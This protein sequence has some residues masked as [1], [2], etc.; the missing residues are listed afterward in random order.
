LDVANI[1][2]GQNN[3]KVDMICMVDMHMDIGFW[4]RT[5]FAY[6]MPSFYA[7]QHYMCIYLLLQVVQKY[8]ML[9]FFPCLPSARSIFYLKKKGK[10]CPDTTWMGHR[11]AVPVLP[12]ATTTLAHI[13]TGDFILIDRHSSTLA[14]FDPNL[15]Y[16]QK[17]WI[18]FYKLF[19]PNQKISWRKIVDI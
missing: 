18:F 8:S 13:I 1:D 17:S 12:A 16:F 3:G 15:C 7:P 4:F 6:Q 19:L 9:L 2:K 11:R 5:G 10:W 14:Q